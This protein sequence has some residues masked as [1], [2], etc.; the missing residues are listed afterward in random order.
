MRVHLDMRAFEASISSNGVCRRGLAR[1]K[2]MSKEIT[3]RDDSIRYK[4]LVMMGFVE[5]L[6]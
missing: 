3:P 4:Q 1:P 2:I 5:G 6:R